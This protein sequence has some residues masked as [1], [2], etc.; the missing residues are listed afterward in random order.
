MRNDRFDIEA[1]KDPTSTLAQVAPMMAHLLANRFALRT[2]IEQ[3][4]VD[5]VDGYVLKMARA[6]GSVVF[7]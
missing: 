6:T 7:S 3:R 5:P 2:R 1:V 4:P